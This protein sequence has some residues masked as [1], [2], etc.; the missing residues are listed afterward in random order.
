MKIVDRFL[1]SLA[2]RSVVTH[3]RENIQYKAEP[4]G[5]NVWQTPPETWEIGSGDCE[6]MALVLREEILDRGLCTTDEISIL[7]LSRLSDKEK[8]ALLQIEK[9]DINGVYYVDT[10]DGVQTELHQ[11]AL[12]HTVKPLMVALLSQYGTEEG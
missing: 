10:V 8:H 12:L 9:K 6:D 4:L 2:L 5:K 1:L 11:Y 3:I 7:I